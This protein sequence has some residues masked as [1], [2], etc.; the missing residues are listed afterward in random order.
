MSKKFNYILI[1]I[2]AISLAF[3]GKK[4]EPKTEMKEEAKTTTDNGAD[5]KIKA[6]EDFVTKYCA[7]TDK[8]KTASATEKVTL[9]KDF[10]ADS[11][12][13]KTLQTDLD[14]VK[15]MTAEQTAKAKAAST[16]ALGCTAS[17]AGTSAPAM[18][19]VKDLPKAPKIP[20][21]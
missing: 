4:E 8:M 5:S 10:K 19:S 15:D 18:P 1:A 17:A 16:K 9:A 6:Y 21:M 7:L 2:L 20:G 12:N 13:L 3:C 11:D 14:S